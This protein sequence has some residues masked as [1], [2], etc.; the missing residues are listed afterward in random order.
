MA[1]LTSGP[2]S[3]DWDIMAG[4]L[5]RETF[6]VVAN[7]PVDLTGATIAAQARKTAPDAE[8]AL[9]AVITPVEPLLGQFTV[10]WDGEAA[11]TLLAGQVSWQGVWDLEVTFAGETL[12][13][14]LLRGVFT[15]N[16]DVTRVTVTPE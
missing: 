11:R 9:E 2:Q 10:E 13:E 5:N 16:M 12:P 14:T 15:V 6:Q 7:D 4:D 8:I 3:L 1:K